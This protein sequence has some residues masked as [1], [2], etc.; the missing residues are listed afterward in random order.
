[1]TGDKIRDPFMS[2]VT[3]YDIDAELAV[4]GASD[5]RDCAP[6][7]CCSDLSVARRLG[8]VPFALLLLDGVESVVSSRSGK[9]RTHTVGS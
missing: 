3:I 2:L 8:R 4:S 7:P 1:M 9:L 5:A 6:L